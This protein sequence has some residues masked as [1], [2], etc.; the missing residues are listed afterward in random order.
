M[1]V[2]V[3]SIVVWLLACAAAQA[4]SNE[5]VK[6]RALYASGTT[7]YNLREYADAL[8]DFKDAYRLHPDPVFLFNIAQ[9]YRQTGDADQAASYYRAFR[10]ESPEAANRADVDRLIDEMD[11]AAAARR[12]PP[13]GPQEPGSGTKPSTAPP[14]ATTEAP[15]P[16]TSRVVAT[17]T[18][19]TTTDRRP[20][21]KKPWFWLTLGGAV[22]VVGG[23]VALGVVLGQPHAPSP[24]I[25]R[26]EGP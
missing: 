26:L 6:A 7:H 2:P 1:R 19:A 18:A 5:A 25:G 4:D 10:R 16:D 22:V 17:H 8:K 11:K 3:V 20:L 13:S 15:A 14:A 9:C 23:A 21:A 12:L 24:S